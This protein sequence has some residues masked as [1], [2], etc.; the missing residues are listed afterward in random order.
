MIS[1]VI[2]PSFFKRAIEVVI[3]VVAMAHETFLLREMKYIL[4][5]HLK[6]D[7][8]LCR[9]SPAALPKRP[10]MVRS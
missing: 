4:R 1:W 6:Y 2:V 8:D 3:V 5:S 9:R 7:K 10:C